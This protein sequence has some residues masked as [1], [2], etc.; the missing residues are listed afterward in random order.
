MGDTRP[1]AGVRVCELS[2]AIAAPTCGKYL[3]YF[4]ADVVKVESPQNPDVI[5]LVG[6][7]TGAAL[8]EFNAGK[9]SVGLDLKTAGGREAMRRLLAA[10]DVFLTN[11]TAPAI[12]R[13][14]L[15]YDE[16]AEAR[17]DIVYAALPGFGSDPAAPYYDFVAWGPNQA[18]LVGLEGLTGYPGEDPAGIATISY[19]DYSSGVHAV[20][21]VLAELRRRAATGAGS[22]IDLSQMEATVSLLGPLVLA[23]QRTGAVPGPTGNRATGI[24]PQGVYPCAGVDRWVA[25]SVADDDRWRALA[26]VAGHPQWATDERLATVADRQRHHD[27]A[28]EVVGGW[29]AAHTMAEVAAWLQAAGVAAAPV[30]DNEALTVDPQLATRHFWALAPNVR[31]GPDLFTG[32]PVRLSSTPGCFASAGPPFAEHT[33]DVLRDVCGYDQGEVDGL[34]AAGAA[35]LPSVDPTEPTDRPWRQ[36][37]RVALPDLD[38][39]AVAAEAPAPSTGPAVPADGGRPTEPVAPGGAGAR[40]DGATAGPPVDGT[41]PAT[42]GPAA[43]PVLDDPDLALSG[44]RVVAVAGPELAQAVRI[45]AGLG[46]EVTLVE[47]PGGGR[48]RTQPSEGVGP[49]LWH[50]AFAGGCG[51]VVVDL[52]APGGAARFADLAAGA[53]VVL[54]ATPPRWL[55]DRD[56]GYAAVSARNPS[57][58]WTSV[59]PF[60]RG[61]PRRDWQGSDLV[62]WAGSG[63]LYTTGHP[64][65]PPVVPGGQALLA[66]HIAAANAAA[67]TLVALAARARTGEGQVVDV[68]MQEATVA[69][70]CETGVPAY[71]SDL[72]HRPRQGNRRPLLRPWGLYACRDG[73]AS[74]VILQPAHWDAL[75]AWMHERC[76][77]ETCTEPIF[78]ELLTRVEV[79][80]LLDSWAEE[81]AATYTKAELFVEGQRRGVPVTPVTTVADLLADAHLA[82]TGFWLDVVDGDLGPVRLPGPPW[83]LPGRAW[84][85]APAPALG[86]PAS[87]SPAPG[88]SPVPGPPSS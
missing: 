32:V 80:D 87:R 46:A 40:P 84:R 30:A 36:W 55:D 29:T 38:W 77:N 63:V 21:A 17:P 68:S 82:A 66:D 76:G 73:W 75:A 15:T 26:R 61:G 45:F 13:L 37:L 5:R 25:I 69:V 10:S 2:I 23:H 57:L 39:E 64:G 60:G 34:V 52:D 83:R 24:A 1:L 20:A 41:T 28:D 54:D 35:H 58:V 88:A 6:R 70:A 11:Y 78:R 56:A 33:V 18:P 71:V 59:T 50:A 49:G 79:P 8:G 51:S 3:A 67:G 85:T 27:L 86:A 4:G 53:D 72:Q 48:L 47:P 44:L 43:P 81:L 14:G 9:R 42:S 12:A 22:C 16:V 31:V 62:A 65:S 19:P 7:D 74:I